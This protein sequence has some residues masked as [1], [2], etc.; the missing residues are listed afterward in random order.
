LRILHSYPATA[1]AFGLLLI[2]M[3]AW[4]GYQGPFF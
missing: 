2:G 3:L 1:A 4:L